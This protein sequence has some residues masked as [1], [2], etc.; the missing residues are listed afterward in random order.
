MVCNRTLSGEGV[1]QFIKHLL[2]RIVSILFFFSELKLSRFFQVFCYTTDLARLSQ[3]SHKALTKSYWKHCQI[4]RP[5]VVPFLSALS[6]TMYQ[7]I[8][9]LVG[10]RLLTK[11]DLINTF[12]LLNMFLITLIGDGNTFI[13]WVSFFKSLDC[14]GVISST[15]PLETD[16]CLPKGQCIEG[17]VSRRTL[18]AWHLRYV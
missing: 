7:I 11:Y 6:Y 8:N 2:L 18:L 12:R 13:I 16:I 17:S 15:K 14:D 1:H 3:V 10:W 4:Q 5:Q 9:L